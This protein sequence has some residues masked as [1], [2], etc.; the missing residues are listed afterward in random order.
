MP[1]SRLP[2]RKRASSR[3]T[4]GKKEGLPG[5]PKSAPEEP[6]S[7]PPAELSFPAPKASRRMR[8]WLRKQARDN[9]CSG[10]RKRAARILRLLG[11]PGA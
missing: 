9:K 3:R 2:W 6:L 4:H 1:L 8:K 11:E 7:G 10:C 5:Q